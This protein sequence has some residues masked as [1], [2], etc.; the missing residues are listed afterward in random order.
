MT[1]HSELKRSETN[2]TI[3]FGV[4]VV[5][6]PERRQVPAEVQFKVAPNT[7]TDITDSGPA[8]LRTGLRQHWES[9]LL[10]FETQSTQKFT[11]LMPFMRSTI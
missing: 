3:H 6:L 11:E 2:G 7:V 9:V 5:G 1:D 4:I 8:R 10:D